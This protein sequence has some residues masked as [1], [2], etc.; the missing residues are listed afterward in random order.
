VCMGEIALQ[1]RENQR[2][3]HSFDL[4]LIDRRRERRDIKFIEHN[5]EKLFFG[6]KQ[7]FSK[8]TCVCKSDENCWLNIFIFKSRE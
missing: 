7:F 5:K 4:S 2:S 8:E 6:N 1:R 3:V